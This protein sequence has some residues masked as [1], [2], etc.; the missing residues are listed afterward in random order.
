MSLC[1]PFFELL[2]VV[3]ESP[4]MLGTCP[5]CPG[6]GQVLSRVVHFG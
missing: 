2:L 1:F 4:L 3:L 5:E 6:R